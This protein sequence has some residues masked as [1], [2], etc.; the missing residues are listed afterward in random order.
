M[1]H[2][3]IRN[4]ADQPGQKKK[5][6]PEPTPADRATQE[7]GE[8]ETERQLQRHGDKREDNDVPNPCAE[9]QILDDSDV[10][11]ETSEMN[12]RRERR[13]SGECGQQA[14]QGWESSQPLSRTASG[15]KR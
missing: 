14:Q 4:R 12:T 6:A 10:V 15:A 11:V 8:A 13:V 3:A 9:L 7:V 1:P 2:D 5:N